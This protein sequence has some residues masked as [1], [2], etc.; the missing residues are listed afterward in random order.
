[1]VAGQTVESHER[2]AT[3]EKGGS[4][5]DGIGIREI[6]TR[7]GAGDE[8]VVVPPVERNPRQIPKRLILDVRG[9]LKF[10]VVVNAEGSG[11]R[12]IGPQAADLRMEKARR[13][14]AGGEKC[15]QP[16]KVRQAHAERRPRNLGTV[17][18]NRK[19]NGRV[20]EIAEV[21]SVVRVLPQLIGINHKVLSECLLEA[22]VKFISL[23]GKNR[24]RRSK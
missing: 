19:E 6:E 10:L 5:A 11:R 14:A 12:Q 18:G 8:A 23:P 20:Q 2:N 9:L 21:I 17:P 15:R 1:M 13:D 3:I 4:A 16:V 24:F 22:C 7:R